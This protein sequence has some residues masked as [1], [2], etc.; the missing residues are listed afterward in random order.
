MDPNDSFQTSPAQTEITHNDLPS[1]KHTSIRRSGLHSNIG[2]VVRVI[3]VP[4][5]RIIMIHCS[6]LSQ[7]SRSLRN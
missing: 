4:F 2:M 1:L 5:I 6:S 3:S 7:I